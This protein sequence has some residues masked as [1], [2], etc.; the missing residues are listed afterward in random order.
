MGIVE[1]MRTAY[2]DR[3]VQVSAGDSVGQIIE[4]IRDAFKRQAAVN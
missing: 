3:L 1:S 2:G 4:S